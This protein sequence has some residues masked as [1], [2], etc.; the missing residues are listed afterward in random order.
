MLT[1]LLFVKIACGID[2]FE[3]L[4]YLKY[5]YHSDNKED[6]KY[7]N[8]TTAFIRLCCYYNLHSM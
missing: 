5:I 8:E 4:I 6:K 3:T 1:S 7:K 2:R